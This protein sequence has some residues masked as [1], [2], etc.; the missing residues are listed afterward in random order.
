MSAPTRTPG[1]RPASSA[2]ARAPR[3]ESVIDGG[4]ATPS[5]QPVTRALAELAHAD[6]SYAVH[7]LS[8]SSSVLRARRPDLAK[9]TT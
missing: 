3:G 8:W 5:H 4:S 7:G 1:Y 2:A 9:P 6:D